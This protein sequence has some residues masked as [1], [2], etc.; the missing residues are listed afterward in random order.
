MGL[1][2]DL[3]GDLGEMQ[4]HGLGVDAWENQGGGLLGLR[5]NGG[6][7]VGG[8]VALVS[9]LSRSAAASCPQTGQRALLADP[10][11][12]LEPDLD[13]LALGQVG[14]MGAQRAREVF[15]YAS[16]IA[17][18]CAGWRGLALIWE[19]PSAFSSLEM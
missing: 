13:R 19:K 17:P 4:V 9:G 7:E 1:G 15:L 12:I 16:T 2:G 18:S 8:G 3:T 14:Q 11:L 5:A 10:G 6:E